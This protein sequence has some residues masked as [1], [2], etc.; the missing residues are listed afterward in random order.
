MTMMIILLIILSLIDRL[1]SLYR[2]ITWVIDMKIAN[3]IKR[4]L[5]RFTN[6]SM[7][8]KKMLELVYVRKRGLKS[9]GIK[10]VAVR[11]LKKHQKLS[12]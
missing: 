4:D 5:Q 3:H 9:C 8:S 12:K 10:R 6:H 7:T 2:L 11:S 1:D